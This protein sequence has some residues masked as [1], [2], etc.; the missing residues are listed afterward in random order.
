[1]RTIPLE[2]FQTLVA[3][4]AIRPRIKRDVRF[5]NATSNQDWGISELIP[6]GDR[7]GNKGIIILE[8]DEANLYLAGYELSRGLTSSTGKA[9]PI[10]CDFCK[11]WQT[12]GRAGSITFHPE[13]RLLNS[14][15]F[16]CCL[17]L[18]CSL[19][20]RDMTEAS[21]LSRVQLREDVS[22]EYRIERLRDKLAL[23]AERLN[24]EPIVCNI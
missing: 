9:Q 3:S 14:I 21:K 2:L 11:T 13:R 16:L 8:D 7:S 10:I 1:M 12:G 23:L 24:L 4:S 5:V 20:V 19:H 18:N 22:R 6:V 17:D 15:S